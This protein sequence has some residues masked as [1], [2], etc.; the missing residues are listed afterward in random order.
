MFRIF[1]GNVL[2]DGAMGT[3]LQRRGLPLGTPPELWNLENSEIVEQIHKDYINSGAMVIE[4]NTFGGNRIRLKRFDLDKKIK[5]INQK[6]VDIAQRASKGKVLIAGSVGPLGEL[7]EPF[8][9]ITIEEAKEVFEEQIEILKSAG[10]D[11]ILIETMIYLE[12]ALCALESALKANMKVGITMSFEITPSG[13]RTS[14]GDTIEKFIKSVENKE[15][16]FLGSNC[17]KGF[18][19]MEK[20]AEE[21]RRKTNKKI[22]IQ[23]N[24]GIPKIVDGK[25]LY[26]G[27]PE[28]FGNFVVKMLKLGINYIGGCCGTTPEHIKKAR[29]IIENF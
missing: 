21:I 13:I 17:G 20:V 16:L 18:E 15:I 26:P 9:D 11:F 14:F 12:E 6:A 25:P 7:L 19:E 27:T 4:T 29:E 3:E 5:V 10:V 1:D 8:G 28:E 22:L 2:F 24:A 23:P